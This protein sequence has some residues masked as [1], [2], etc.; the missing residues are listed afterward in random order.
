MI[1]VNN[2]PLLWKVLPY[3]RLLRYKLVQYK[4]VLILKKISFS[5]PIKVAKTFKAPMILE[6]REMDSLIYVTV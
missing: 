3:I 2:S 5:P 4:L 1:F 6:F